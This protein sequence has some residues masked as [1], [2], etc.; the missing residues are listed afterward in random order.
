M[1]TFLG[2]SSGA[3]GTTPSTSSSSDTGG[4]IGGIS[5]AI[6]G[7][8]SAGLNYSAQ[9]DALSWKKKQWGEQKLREDSAHQREVRD[10]RLAGLS[11]TLSASGSGAQ[12]GSPIDIRPPQFDTGSVA[13][14]AMEVINLVQ[15]KKNIDKTNAE[16]QLLQKQ[17][18]LTGANAVKQRLDNSINEKYGYNSNPSS[19]GKILRDSQS[20]T[21]NWFQ[22]LRETGRYLWQREKNIWR[23][24][25]NKLKNK[26]K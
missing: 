20:V 5:S 8:V 4:I 16:I 9:Q 13:N 19:F 25:Y 14:A 6:A 11:P 12:T 2:L 23:P 15:G 26:F 17:K 18:Q 22:R 21:D 3:S 10:L 24:Y 7:I 1:P